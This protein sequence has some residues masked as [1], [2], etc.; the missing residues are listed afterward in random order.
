MAPPPRT[1]TPCEGDYGSK[2]MVRKIIFPGPE[3]RVSIASEQSC[4]GSSDSF[5]FFVG[6]AEQKKTN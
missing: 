2:A 1:R 4:L 5:S 3:L 6:T